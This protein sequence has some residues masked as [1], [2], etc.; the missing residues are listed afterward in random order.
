MH[1]VFSVAQFKSFNAF[2]KK[3]FKRT[4]FFS[5]S[6]FVEENTNAINFFEIKKII[7]IKTNS[8]RIF[9]FDTLIKI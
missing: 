1:L 7:I 5:D 2:S 6:I 8:K 4:V 9:F 3:K